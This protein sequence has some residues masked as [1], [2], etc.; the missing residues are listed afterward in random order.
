[1]QIRPKPIIHFGSSVLSWLYGYSIDAI[2]FSVDKDIVLHGVCLFGGVN[3]TY[4][5]E[6]DVIDPYT[7]SIFVSKTGE[8][9][10]ELLQGKNFNYYGYRVSFDKKIILKKNTRYDIRAKITGSPS[11]RGEGGVSSVQCSGVTFTFMDSDY[12]DNGTN[13]DLGQF[14]ELLFSLYKQ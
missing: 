5:V 2:S 9:S 4:S 3:N 14:P 12:L 10:S 8:C 1:L 6:L 7:K 13:V 11:L